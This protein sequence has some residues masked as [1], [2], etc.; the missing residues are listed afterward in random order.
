MFVRHRAMRCRT[1]G[2]IFHYTAN[3]DGSN[4]GVEYSVHRSNKVIVEQITSF[5]V[6]HLNGNSSSIDKMFE[7][8]FSRNMYTHIDRSTSDS[9]AISTNKLSKF[10]L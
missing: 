8:I 7:C 9:I 3:V 4:I 2:K 5:D 6:L 1:S 10:S